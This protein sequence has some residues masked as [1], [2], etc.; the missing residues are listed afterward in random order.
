[1]NIRGRHRRRPGDGNRRRRRIG[2]SRGLGGRLGSSTESSGASIDSRVIHG[3]RDRH[4]GLHHRGG[5]PKTS[6]LHTKV[7]RRQGGAY[8]ATMGLEQGGQG[9]DWPYVQEAAVY[10]TWARK[11]PT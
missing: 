1:M 4:R 6:D 11:R 9:A 3:R 10:L 8:Q 5:Q 7:Y 2:G